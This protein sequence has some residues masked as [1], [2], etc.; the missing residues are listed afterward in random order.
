MA[1]KD[2]QPPAPRTTTWWLV[3]P[4]EGSTL[5]EDGGRR[6][7][8]HGRFEHERRQVPGAVDYCGCHRCGSH[9]HRAV[10]C[11]A[12][13]QD[14]M[15]KMVGRHGALKAKILVIQMMA[16]AEV[17]AASE[18]GQQQEQPSWS[19]V[20]REG[21]PRRQLSDEAKAKYARRRRVRQARQAAQAARRKIQ[22]AQEA[23]QRGEYPAPWVTVAEARARRK[24]AEAER[25]AAAHR[26]Q[27]AQ[28]VRQAEVQRQSQV[29]QSK[30]QE[31]A[32]SLVRGWARHKE[33][34][35]EG[36]ARSAEAEVGRA[37]QQEQAAQQ[38][39][40][41]QRRSDRQKA[42]QVQQQFEW[43][44]QA[45]SGPSYPAWDAK[46]NVGVKSQRKEKSRVK[47]TGLVPLQPDVNMIDMS[48]NSPCL[49]IPCLAN[50][51][52]TEQA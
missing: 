13:M 1:G 51:C 47:N 52:L 44:V 43:Q 33:A 40:A 4:R 48:L 28:Q 24:E 36:Q 42:Q 17:R 35:A 37:R 30:Q 26:Q 46:P 14:W 22:A 15:V 23:V 34:D 38:E 49:R 9:E 19:Q 31:K 6:R 21:A 11:D 41:K 25:R 2:W 32:S 29:Q 20:V 8:A 5:R 16:K 7:R 3:D 50:Q 12:T 10:E 18:A 39:L 27:M 45:P